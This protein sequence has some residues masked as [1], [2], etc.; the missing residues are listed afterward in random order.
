MGLKQQVSDQS[1][2]RIQSGPELFPL[3]QELLDPVFTVLGLCCAAGSPGQGHV[4]R[5][6]TGS[7]PGW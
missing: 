6:L 4:L 1:V 3:Y 5:P 7:G 2:S